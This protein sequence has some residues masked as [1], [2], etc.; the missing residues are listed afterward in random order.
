MGAKN[1]PV[2]WNGLNFILH[3]VFC[4]AFQIVNDSNIQQE[5]QGDMLVPQ[6]NFNS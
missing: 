2:G 5:G 6:F 3:I 4:A 1:D